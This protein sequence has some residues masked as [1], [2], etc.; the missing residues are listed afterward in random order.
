MGTPFAPLDLMFGRDQCTLDVLGELGA[1]LGV[2][3]GISEFGDRL[4]QLPPGQKG[5]G[6]DS[7]FW[8]LTPF[9][10]IPVPSNDAEWW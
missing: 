5:S 3:A 6:A 8:L 9:S 7:V 10:V 2:V 4:L 1:A